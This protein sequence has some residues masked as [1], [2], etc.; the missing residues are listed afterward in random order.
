MTSKFLTVHMSNALYENDEV[1]ES[2]VAGDVGLG[3]ALDFSQRFRIVGIGSLLLSGTA[4]HLHDYLHK[5]A[6]AFIHFLRSGPRA[7][8]CSKADAFFDAVA[9]GDV[10]AATELA[11][12]A[13]RA[14]DRSVEYPED[15]F[16]A[17]FL[18]DHFFLGAGAEEGKELLERYEAAL[19]GDEDPRLGA[20]R[21]L[22]VG[23]AEALDASLT[24]MM[25]AR[26][27]RYGKLADK[28]LLREE[29]L[30]TEGVVSVEGLALVRLAATQGLVV[31]DEHLFIPSVAREVAPPHY[32]ADD[33]QQLQP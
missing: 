1:L 10:Q 31:S 25:E 7:W 27:S 17:R 5:S 32:A 14:A 19:E 33:W 23:D 28:G 3:A 6:R 24:R 15:F 22:L 8:P 4:T 11:Q 12:L 29:L 13:P 9:C 18:M 16:Y 2:F 21:S 26:E 20:C 30:A